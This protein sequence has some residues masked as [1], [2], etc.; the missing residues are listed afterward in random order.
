MTARETAP[1]TISI[2]TSLFNQ[3][4]RTKEFLRSLEAT[5]GDIRYEVILVD[6]ASSDETT[7]FLDELDSS[8]RVLRNAENK[9]FAFAN[10][11]G[12]K[13]A[14]SEVLAFLNNDLVLTPG[15]FAP[16]FDCLISQ[17]RVGC[18]GNVQLDA[19]S[20]RIDH[21]GIYFEVDGSAR[22]AYKGRRYLSNLAN[23]PGRA[24]TGACF[25][26]KKDL[27]LEAGGF[28]TG[29]T[30]GLEDIDL[31]LRLG[32]RGYRHFVCTSSRVYHWVSSSRGRGD[33]ESPANIE[34]FQERWGGAQLFEPKE[35][36]LGYIGRYIGRPWLMHPFRA[37]RAL[38]Y[39]IRS[40]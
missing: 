10:N 35:W 27:F 34:R 4:D 19:N 30:N 40:G 12:A 1:P 37:I 7:D 38:C 13:I 2:V 16:M 33:G 8:Y 20:G 15:W 5:L 29:Y 25:L 24:L 3:L 11:R 21:A 31:C 9:G 36:A 6:D 17:E 26:I 39:L 22:H 32:E 14:K 18:V 23:S 28:D